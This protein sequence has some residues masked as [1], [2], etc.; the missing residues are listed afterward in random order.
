MPRY[1][2]ERRI[3]NA[4]KFNALEL[5]DISK[6]SNEVLEDMRREGKNIQWVQSYVT[7]HAI[8]CLYVAADANLVLEHAKRGGL[9]ADSININEV[10]EIIDPVTGE[11]PFPI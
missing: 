10:R 4:G 1:L 3:P 11:L 8:H 6:K 2:I 9:P 5:K 7:D